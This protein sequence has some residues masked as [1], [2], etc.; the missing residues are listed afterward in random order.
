MAI[1]VAHRAPVERLAVA[2]VEGERFLFDVGA[3]SGRR[4]L[5]LVI[6]RAAGEGVVRFGI[7]VAVA[8]ADFAVGAVGKVVV[9]VGEGIVALH[10]KV[11]PVGA[12]EAL[13]RQG[14]QFAVFVGGQA[15]VRGDVA[16]LVEV[17]DAGA[18]VSGP[19]SQSSAA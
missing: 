3:E 1:F 4:H 14:Q 15:V 18:V 17:A 13:L 11:V 8:Q 7:A 10:F 9:N 5:Q 19:M 16:L 12:G 6:E 2:G